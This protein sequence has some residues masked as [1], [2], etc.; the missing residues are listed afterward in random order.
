MTPKTSAVIG[1]FVAAVVGLSVPA[2][3]TYACS[4]CG[5]GDPLVN[6]ADAMPTKN[7]I[8]LSLGAQWLKA[9][10]QSDDDPS[11]TEH[12]V[13]ET[14]RPTVVYSPTDNLNLVLQVPL[15]RKAWS[16][17]G[18]TQPA[19]SVTALG[20]GDI[21]LSGRLFLWQNTDFVARSRQSFG[22]FAGTSAPTGPNDKTADGERIDDHAQ[23]GTGSFGP[24]VGLVYAY[25]RDPW[26]LYSS[27]SA[28]YHTTNS[29]DYQYAPALLWTVRGQ[30]RPLDW[31]ALELGVDGRFNGKDSA[32]GDAQTNTGGLVLAASPGAMAR[33]TD[34][35]WLH[36]RGQ[37]PVYTKLNGV[38]TVG[39]VLSAFVQYTF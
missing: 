8:R 37:L 12:L 26:N 4:V 36:L 25:H 24:Y 32:D 10:A 15:M 22:V 39:P 31:L 6:A 9:S 27:V 33:I 29:Y 17:D 19:E 20:L 16:L 1:T 30:W 13:Q 35:L 23:L 18:G 11:Q 34:S 28:T 3:P 21:K 2:Q 38:Q 14:L 5:C 7:R